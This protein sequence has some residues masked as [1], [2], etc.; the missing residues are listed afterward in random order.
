[1]LRD[2]IERGILE[3]VVPGISIR[4]LEMLGDEITRGRL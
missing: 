3:M 1:M 4:R 2:E